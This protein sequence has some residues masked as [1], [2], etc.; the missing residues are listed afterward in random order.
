MTFKIIAESAPR[1]TATKKS[2]QLAL[3]AQVKIL[4]LLKKAST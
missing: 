4:H 2:L 3:P 1:K